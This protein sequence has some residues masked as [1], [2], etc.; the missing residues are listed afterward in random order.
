M[1]QRGV[2]SPYVLIAASDLRPNDWNPNRM[3]RFIRDKAIESIKAYGFIDPLTVMPHEGRYII[4]DGEHRF[5][6]GRDEFSMDEFPCIVIDHISLEDA[7]KLTVVLNELHGQADPGRLGDL[8][9]DLLDGST[10]DDVLTAL[11]FTP[12]IVASLTSLSD[13]TLPDMPK[14]EKTPPA[15]AWVERLYRFPPDVVVVIDAAIARSI[16]SAEIEDGDTIE[17]WQALERICADYLAG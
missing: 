7:K 17:P 16:S 13:I 8:L 4:I 1:S 12:E 10:M 14:T 9:A 6:I 5:L 2:V 15:G 11:P 3:T